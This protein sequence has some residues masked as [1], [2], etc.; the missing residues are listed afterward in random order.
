MQL[1]AK[2]LINGFQ[3]KHK[4]RKFN[5]IYPK[6][7][8][9]QNT[10]LF[11]ELVG[12]LTI[13]APLVAEHKQLVSNT[14][15]PHF[16]SKYKQMVLKSIPPAVGG[17]RM[18]TVKKTAQFKEIKY[19]FQGQNQLE[20]LDYNVSE[21][22][23]VCFSSGKDSLLS[24]GV[25]KEI[26][27]KPIMYYVNDTISPSEN[28]TK[29]RFISKIAKEQKLRSIIVTNQI[30]NFNDFE[31]WDKPTT[32]LPYSHMMTG[33][34]M[35]SL[36]IAQQEKIKYIIHGNQQDMQYTYINKD[37]IRTTS[38]YDQTIEWQKEQDKIVQQITGKVRVTSL[39][40]PLA[41]FASLK[42]LFNRYPKLAKYMISCDC[43]DASS[44][45]RWCDECNKC[46]R[47]GII[48]KAQGFEP[49]TVGLKTMLKKEHKKYYTL[50]TSS[51]EDDYENNKEAREQQLLAFYWAYKNKVKGSLID[52][53]KKKFLAE[54]KQKEDYLI[55]KFMTPKKPL[56]LPKE[57]V[58]P[59]LSIYKE[60]LVYRR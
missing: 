21:K 50:F 32:I 45:R 26:G 39:I 36:P 48:M 49:K 7:Y 44:K 13:D 11:N 56:G 15:K 20:K 19:N 28:N 14:L 47:I 12:L 18:N 54:A 10:F 4:R 3:I 1:Q 9:K 33:F 59:V 53:F 29:L 51:R 58:K 25:A 41:N 34:S 43:L 5:L 60:E 31:Y 8:W 30:E 16:F 35:I 2:Q 24:L 40:E 42:I 46:A 27:L 17:T 23:L 22:A 55:K 57:I 6:K 52:Y 38:S 37:G